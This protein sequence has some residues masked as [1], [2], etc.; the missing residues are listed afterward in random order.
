VSVREVAAAAGV[1]HALIH[2]HFGSKA[3][4]VRLVVADAIER[5]DRAVE[6]GQS[7]DDTLAAAVAATRRE[8]TAVRLVAWAMLSDCPVE[9]V[10]ATHPAAATIVA[11]LREAQEAAGRVPRTPLARPEAAVASAM[12]MML[13]WMIF[14]PFVLR[15]SGLDAEGVDPAIAAAAECLFAEA[16]GG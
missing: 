13:G 10:A 6:A 3:D 4:L 15:A 11:R 16:R 9:S 12:A 2:R 7:I 14:E 8:V 1:N 5:I